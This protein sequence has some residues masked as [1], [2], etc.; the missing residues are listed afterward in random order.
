VVWRRA[1]SRLKQDG[2]TGP[3]VNDPVPDALVGSELVI[4]ENGL[5]F[6]VSVEEGQKT[7]FYCDQRTNRLA[8]R[9]IATGKTVLDTYCYSGG[10]ALNALAGG[11]KNVVAVDSS[12]P[13]LDAAAQN[14]RLNG[15][16]V[17]DGGAAAAGGGGSAAAGQLEIVKGD[18][19]EVMKRLAEKQTTFDVVICDPPK[20]APS[21]KDLDR[22][23]NK[24]LN[25]N[26]L[27]MS[28]V[29]PGGILLTCTCSAAMT[30]DSDSGFLRML[31][32]A[33]RLARRDV[34]VL[35]TSGAAPDHPVSVNYQEG[36]YLTAIALHVH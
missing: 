12:Q 8:L 21:R 14:A 33:A 28:L 19:V 17:V 1:E 29:S 6:V 16:S 25:I 5:K 13:A 24:Y 2:W 27:A 7:G 22:A 10:F 34:S 18:C 3:F 23:R 32:D 36:A 26:K 35:S 20:L 31:G 30:Q 15:F 11:A 4:K 9:S